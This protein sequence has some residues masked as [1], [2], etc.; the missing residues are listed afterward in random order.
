MT[1]V[2]SWNVNS[3]RARLDHLG[4]W[5][6]G[7]DVDLLAVQE[8]K[9]QD[10]DFPAAEIARLGYRALFA[11]QK[12]YTGVAVLARGEPRL[13]ADG[14]PGFDDPQRRVL[15]VDVDGLRLVNLYVPNGSAVGSDK[16]DYKLRWLDALAEWAAQLLEEAPETLIVGDFNI[17]P[18]DADVHDPAAWEGRILCSEPERERLERLFALGYVDVFRQF[19]Q[20]PATFSWWDYR[21]GGFRRNQGLRIDLILAAPALAGA[22]RACEVDAEPRGWEKPSDHA[23][24][25]ARLERPA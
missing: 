6:G 23:P 25:V 7:R 22:V 24:V 14:L 21:G 16:Y 18:A 8:T 3:L 12:S 2:A 19:E 1:T 15:A 10:H 17:A 13:V 9:V 4:R 5:L 20:A 11:G